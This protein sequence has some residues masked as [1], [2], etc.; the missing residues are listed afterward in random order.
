MCTK[1]VVVR[2]TV[3]V[4]WHVDLRGCEMRSGR[5]DPGR[6]ARR[7]HACVGQEEWTGTEPN[8]R[9]DRKK[10]HVVET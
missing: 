3:G 6:N 9:E 5:M 4:G 2:A 1:G 7:T 10:V 8:G